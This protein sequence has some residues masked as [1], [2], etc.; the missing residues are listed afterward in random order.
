M[1]IR[2]QQTTTLVF[3]FQ[4]GDKRLYSNKCL[5]CYNS[6]VLHKKLVGDAAGSGAAPSGDKKGGKGKDTGAP[7]G[8]GGASKDLDMS[9]K[10]YDDVCELLGYI[11]PRVET[12]LTGRAWRPN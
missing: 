6:P 8:G 1:L 5:L 10:K 2:Q 9:D 7:K 3:T 11:D 12:T 4:I